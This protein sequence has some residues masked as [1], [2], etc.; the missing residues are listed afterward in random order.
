MNTKQQEKV[1]A[2]K[3]AKANRKIKK[4]SKNAKTRR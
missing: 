2:Q 4:V 1:L 3:E